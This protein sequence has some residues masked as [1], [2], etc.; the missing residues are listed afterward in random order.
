MNVLMIKSNR[1]LNFMFDVLILW[2]SYLFY[3]NNRSAWIIVPFLL[4]MSCLV[5]MA[6]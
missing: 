2:C 1:M 3:T 6:L 5:M 4:M